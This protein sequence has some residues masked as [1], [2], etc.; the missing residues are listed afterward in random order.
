MGAQKDTVV[1]GWVVGT[2]GPRVGLT[3]ELPPT[4]TFCRVAP[5]PRP[6][7][8]SV[9]HIP[10]HPA[11]CVWV[12]GPA[13]E[14]LP[15]QWEGEESDVRVVRTPRPLTGICSK[16]R[17]APLPPAPSL[18]GHLRGTVASCCCLLGQGS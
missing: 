12:R 2:E 8:Q 11:P 6:A 3:P 1:R 4:P 15:I 18:S 9:W 17:S 10:S 5:P 16:A 7:C 13:P 14:M